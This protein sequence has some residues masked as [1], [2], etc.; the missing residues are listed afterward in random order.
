MRK[1]LQ[2]YYTNFFSLLS[3]PSTDFSDIY[4]NQKIKVDG[5]FLN[6]VKI[7]RGAPMVLIHGWAN[8]W[9]GWIPLIKH[10]QDRFTLY[11]IDLPGFGDSGNLANY[12]ISIAADYVADF[13]KLIARE[14]ASLMGLSMGS[15]VAAETARLYPKLFD[16]VIL[17]GPLLKEN[18]I[19]SKLLLSSMML[20]SFNMSHLSKKTLKKILETRILAYTI[21]KY[22]N[23]YRF[24]RQMVDTYGTRGKK[25]MRIESFIQMGLSADKYDYTSVLE[26]IKVPTMMVYGRE[27]RIAS[28]QPAEK[29]LP[30][31]NKLHLKLIP[32]AGHMVHWEQ[33]INLS[34]IIKRF[35][36]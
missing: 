3:P 10:L 9:E 31:N 27:D 5:I 28:Y 11:L 18:K 21:S 8:N 2:K 16:K 35:V 6:Y 33:P 15:F 4:K 29:L 14:P 24:N 7:G 13:V 22:F 17:L 12:S 1:K 19:S 23:M 25:K 26:N 36:S 20:K 34:K 32:L 30:L